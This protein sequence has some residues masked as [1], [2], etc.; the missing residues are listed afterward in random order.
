MSTE[1][2]IEKIMEL[3]EKQKIDKIV[4]FVSEKDAQLRAAVARALALIKNDESYNALVTLTHDHDMA[5]RKEAVTSLGELGMASAIT[6]IMY[7]MDSTDDPDFK[8]AC[9]AAHEKLRHLES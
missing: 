4:K 8:A 5:V 7:A 2:K 6:H 3:A 9:L 1:K